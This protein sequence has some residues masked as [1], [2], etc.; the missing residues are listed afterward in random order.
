MDIY[1][2]SDDENSPQRAGADL[3]RLCEGLLLVLDAA[4]QRQIKAGLISDLISESEIMSRA[5]GLSSSKVRFNLEC[6][7]SGL[8]TSFFTRR[9]LK[10]LT[11]SKVL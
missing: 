6:G 7:K 4:P 11:S 10:T 3:R 9:K 8:E 2:L 1:L 5:A